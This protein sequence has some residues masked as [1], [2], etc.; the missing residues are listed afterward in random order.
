MRRVIASIAAIL[1]ILVSRHS[2]C[3]P[4]P[5]RTHLGID[6]D[7]WDGQINDP[8]FEQSLRRMGIDFI[9]WHILPYEEA[10]PT[11]LDAIVQF[12]RKNR[13]EYLF[14]TEIGNYERDV[15]TFEHSD[16]TYRYD[17]AVSTLELLKNDPF[18]LGV[19]YDEA[20]L[21]QSML[22]ERDQKGREIRPYFADTRNLTAQ[23]AFLE[24]SGKVRELVTRYHAYGKRVIFEMVF[25]DYPFAFA[26]GG[27]L[28][29]PKL[30]KENYDDL[31]YGV[32]RGAALEYN[33][34]ELWACVDLWFLDRFPF[35]GKYSSGFHTPTELLDSL[36]Y[37]YN[38][39]FDYVYIEQYKAL[40]DKDFGLTEFGKKVVDFRSW[41]KARSPGDWRG[42][43]IQFYVRR[44]P[45]GYWG[46]VYSTFIPDH[47]YGSWKVNPY[48]ASDGLWLKKL[49]ELSKGRIPPDADTWNAQGSST[50]KTTPYQMLAGLPP[51][52]VFDQFGV[53]PK[54]KNAVVFDFLPKNQSAT[55]L[56]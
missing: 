54:G 35:N 36:K 38:A 24:V 25:P 17:L 53:I 50:F 51:F 3:A 6:A 1:L 31:M 29:A 11:R 42:A 4:S 12:C 56:E 2:N 13:W 10:D 40:L 27:G 8:R 21:M 14:N 46:Q 52:V 44:F 43:P 19:V 34:P 39:G 30:L 48:T 16:G 55:G 22:G 26:R 33:L 28:L 9:S 7:N 49:N 32:Y 41:S 15:P 47:P 20:E 23:Q 5:R 37:S 45:D 18:F